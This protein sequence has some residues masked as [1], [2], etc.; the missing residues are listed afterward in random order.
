[1]REI[2]GTYDEL[3]LRKNYEG[4]AT[5][6]YLHVIL[7]DEEDVPDAL[8]RLRTIYPNIMKL[9]YDNRRTRASAD[10]GMAEAI[11]KKSGVELFDE[12]YTLQNGQPLSEEQRAFAEEVLESLKEGTV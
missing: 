11:E 10:P 1:M 5:D 6:D 12:F 4:T 2:R 3:A 9:D 7:T 8:A